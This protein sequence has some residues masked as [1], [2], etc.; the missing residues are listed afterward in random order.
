VTVAIVT[1]WVDHPELEADY[2][3][4]IRLANPDE[5]IIV[6]NGSN[7]PLEYATLRNP[8]NE[9]FTRANNQGLHYATSDAVV[10][11]NNDI[12][13][14]DPDWL[15]ALRQ[16][17]E[18]G[19]LAGARV[20]A[21]Y[22]AAVDGQAFPYID[23]WCLAGM[24]DD[25]LNLGGWDETLDEPAYYSDNLL[26]LEARAAGMRL[27]EARV[28]LRHKLNQTAAGLPNVS[29]ATMTNRTQYEKRVREL[30]VTA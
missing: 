14:T 24:R 17:V 19:V 16:A 1:A 6:D 25:L 10:F 4:A 12:V 30:M 27:V 22:H 11:L 5:V 28:G 15:D 29:A 20:R 7:P 9:G 26:S 21:D 8:T 23:G 2:F 3:E 13:A 18:P